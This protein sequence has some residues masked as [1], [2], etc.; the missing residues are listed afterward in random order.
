MI[1][2]L[3]AGDDFLRGGIIAFLLVLLGYCIK[4][5]WEQL[6]KSRAVTQRRLAQQM[7]VPSIGRLHSQCCNCLGNLEH[8]ETVV[9]F[10]NGLGERTSQLSHARCCVALRQ[11]DGQL[12]D[13][14]G[15]GF[16]VDSPD[17]IASW[18]GRIIVVMTPARWAE[19]MHQL[20]LHEKGEA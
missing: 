14:S 9:W 3:T 12:T 18:R 4:R 15:T 2:R 16:G 13:I 7:R 6:D 8:G 11:E 1:Q 5:L 10:A 19:S 20:D 17:R